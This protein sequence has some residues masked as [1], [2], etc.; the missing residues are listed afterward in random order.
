[1]PSSIMNI[2][3]SLQEK[4]L[5]YQVRTKRDPD[6]FAELYD[7]YVEP[8]YRFVYL[9]VSNKEEAEDLTSDIFLRAWDYLIREEE[10]AVEN[11]RALIYAIARNRIVDLY[12]ERARRQ[13]WLVAVGESEPELATPT[14]KLEDQNTDLI[15]PL[16]KTIQQ[17]KQEYQ[18]VIHLKYIED[19]STRQ[20]AQI[21]GKSSTSV[22]VTLHRALK[23]LKELTQ[24]YDG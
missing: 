24:S 22:R 4:R 19:L 15:D 5:L 20:I 16:L 17:L 1:M 10:R 9:K 12:R 18:D 3:S 6:A 2:K 23:K 21:L 8:I 7:K 11:F 13:E 14:V